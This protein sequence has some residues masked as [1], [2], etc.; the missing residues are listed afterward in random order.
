MLQFADCCI[1]VKAKLLKKWPPNAVLKQERTFFCHTI[2]QSYRL[3]LLHNVIHLLLMEQLCHPQYIS[4]KLVSLLVLP[5]GKVRRKWGRESRTVSCTYHF[6]LH[7]FFPK[8]GTYRV[9]RKAEKCGLQLG[10]QTL[11]QM[12]TGQCHSSFAV[13]YASNLHLASDV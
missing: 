9:A 8:L 3:A 12:L 6:H 4:F 7:P 11:L 13:C 10:G 2:F 5:F 1:R